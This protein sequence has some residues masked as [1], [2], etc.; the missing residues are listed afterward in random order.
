MSI[1]MARV[2]DEIQE[3][4]KSLSKDIGALGQHVTCSQNMLAIALIV[5]EQPIVL[6]GPWGRWLNPLVRRGMI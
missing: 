3:T 6:T 5:L 1:G 4:R 2:L